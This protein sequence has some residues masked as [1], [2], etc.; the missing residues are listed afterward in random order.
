[1][2][3]GTKC[4]SCEIEDATNYWY[5]GQPLCN[6]CRLEWEEKE[7]RDRTGFKKEMIGKKVDDVKGSRKEKSKLV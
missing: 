5:G 1:M 2:I 3:K 4:Q 6:R 7:K